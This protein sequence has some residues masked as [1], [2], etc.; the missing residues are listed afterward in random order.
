MVHPFPCGSK[1][2]L[3]RN[4]SACFVESELIVQESL[5]EVRICQKVRSWRKIQAQNLAGGLLAANY[6][7]FLLYMI[8][9]VC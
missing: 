4:M 8:L 1:N 7:V 3:L 5:E 2:L 9:S 6:F